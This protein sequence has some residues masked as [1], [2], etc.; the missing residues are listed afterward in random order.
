MKKSIIFLFLALF[1]LSVFGQ[2]RLTPELLWELDRVGAPVASPDGSMIAFTISDY[3]LKDNRGRTDIYIMSATGG[4]PKKLTGLLESSCWE[5]EWQPNGKRLSYLT[6]A[7]GEGQI[8]DVDVNNPEDFRQ[9]TNFEGGISGFHYAK[10][11]K[12]IVFSA[13]VKLDQ[14]TQDIYPDLPYADGRVINDLMYRHWDNWDD[15]SYSHIFYVN[16]D[17]LAGQPMGEPVDLMRSERFDSPLEPFG[18]SEEFAI[19]PDGR[20]VVYTCKKMEGKDYAKSTNS[21]IFLVEIEVGH[22][23]NLSAYNIGYDKNPVFS[24]DGTQLSWSQ[25]QTPGYESD[26]NTIVVY[27]LESRQF[28]DVL[29]KH[30]I[31]ANH[32]SWGVKDKMLYFTSDVQGTVHFFSLDL[33]K[34]KLNQISKGRCNYGGYAIVGNNFIT[35]RSTMQE[36]NTLFTVD[37][38]KGESKRFLNWNREILDKLDKGTVRKHWVKTTT[39]EKMLTWL[40]LPPNFDS[41]KKYP[42]LLYCQG[43]PQ[44]AIS[45]YYSFRW[46]FELMA[47][48]DYIIVAPNRHGVPG[49]GQEYNHQIS[50]D[51]GGQAMRDYL[52][53]IDWA[54]K[55]P[56]VNEKKMGC[57]G[58][59]YGGYSVYWLAGH[60]KRRFKCFIAH[61][62]LFNLDSWYATTEE[63][64]FAD[65]DL[66]GA[67]WDG[68]SRRAYDAFNPANFVTYWDAPILV[69]HGEK[70]FRVPIGE[71]L[72]AFNTAQ[73]R[74]IKSRF[75]YFPN[76]GHWVQSPQNG[77]LWHREYF[78]WLDEN[79]K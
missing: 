26:K 74:G 28:E 72:Q 33:K 54:S 29:A 59:S 7:A 77:V 18:G 24:S 42:T 45:Q 21:D 46:N 2:K 51:W 13:K 70:D 32:V 71:G 41:T 61:C 47:A 75:L 1:G 27:D 60:H 16:L 68:S 40:I 50:G 56:Y 5:P 58:A 39:G 44:A 64:F 12:R 63:M 79:L 37:M 55:L 57:V 22:S 35:Q 43:G 69:I 9:I 34:K 66:K 38:K 49:F 3:T 20:K 4:E 10:N 8:F 73:L 67:P 15:Y 53:A 14:T 76:E 11:G 31:S 19:S 17:P 30:D 6:I 48:N 65:Y 23:E 25:M 52:K 62:G 36:P 78:K